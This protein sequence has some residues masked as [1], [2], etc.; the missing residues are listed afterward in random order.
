GSG[1]GGV[2]HGSDGYP[3]EAARRVDE[4]QIEVRAHGGGHLREALARGHGGRERMGLVRGDLPDGQQREPFDGAVELHRGDLR[5]PG[6]ALRETRTTRHRLRQRETDRP[7]RVGID[8]QYAMAR[9]GEREAEVEREGGLA[10][11]PFLAGNDERF[12]ALVFSATGG[13]NL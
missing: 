7:L 11:A 5:F 3:P 1:G 13:T 10:D 4:A 8:E 6:D 12:H 2:G 9:L